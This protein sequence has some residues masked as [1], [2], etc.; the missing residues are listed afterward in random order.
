[1]ITGESHTR[2]I[3]QSIWSYY[4]DSEPDYGREGMERMRAAYDK[5]VADETYK[6]IIQSR[7]AGCA[8][9]APRY[10]L[11]PGDGGDCVLLE[12]ANA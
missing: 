5:F 1:M 4:R 8:F 12:K 2:P 9:A 7:V 6:L 10:V 3:V 11:V